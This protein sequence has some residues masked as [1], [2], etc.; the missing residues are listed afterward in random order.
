MLVIGCYTALRYSDLYTVGQSHV[1]NNMIKIQNFKTTNLVYIPI[2]PLVEEIMRKYN[3]AAPKVTS[4]SDMNEYIKVVCK[5]AGLTHE[6]ER[7][8]TVKGKKTRLKNPSIQA[9][10]NSTRNGPAATRDYLGRKLAQS[11]LLCNQSRTTHP[12]LTSRLLLVHSPPEP[13]LL[14]TR[15]NA[16]FPN[17]DLSTREG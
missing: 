16:R 13:S 11:R 1:E 6:V 8:R 12:R 7:L 3:G 5:M 9:P 2:H 17:P 14:R 15:L 10:P 4:N